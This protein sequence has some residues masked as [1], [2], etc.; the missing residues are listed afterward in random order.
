MASL[1]KPVHNATHEGGRA[2]T[3][4]DLETLR[5][6]VL[7]CLLW[8]D[9]FYED[10]ELTSTRIQRL[11]AVCDPQQVALLALEARNN[12]QL[13]HVPLL[14]V[15]ELARRGYVNTGITL[16]SVIQRPDEITEFL[17]IY[18]KDGKC[19]LSNQVKKGLAIAFNKFNAY[20]LAKYNRDGAVKLRDALFLCHAKPVDDDQA[21]VWKKL[22]DGTLEAPDTWE[23]AL[24][25][26]E[27]KKEAWTRLLTENKLGGLATLRNLRN[28]REVGV[29]DALVRE[30]LKQ[31]ISRAL[32]FRFISAAKH[33]PQYEPELEVAM[34]GSM[35]EMPKLPGK[36]VLLVDV[37]GS[38][39]HTTV[40]KRSELTRLDA[41]AGLAAM[42]RELCDDIQIYTF[43]DDVIHVPARR[44]FGLIDLIKNSTHRCTYLRKATQHINNVESYDRLIVLTDEQSHDGAGAVKA[45]ARGYLL[46]VA[47]YQNGVN[48]GNGWT[49]I[50][51]WS[52]KVFDYIAASE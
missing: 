47:T 26:G 8:E 34:L 12:M 35:S 1:N 27:D 46:N 6:T 43:S 14:L 10:G 42:A 52:E 29:P 4:G 25:S 13:R 2:S 45:G 44:G 21:S 5:R 33:A 41:A 49:H 18:W 36:T 7:T 23:V 39:V 19:P 50:N 20:Q 15:R 37:S 30:R 9:N 17:A 11:C 40:S 28:M 3:V 24:S 32:P 48:Y 38:M 16:A 22:V 31:P 51:G